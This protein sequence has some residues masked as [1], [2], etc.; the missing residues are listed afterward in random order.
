VFLDWLERNRRHRFVAWLQYMEPHDPYTPPASMRPPVPP[1]MP[2]DLAAGWV[3]DVSRRLGNP[4]TPPLTQ[5]QLAYLR[6]LYDGEIRSWDAELP[7]LLRGLERLGL[8][9]S[10]LIVVT[11]DHGEEFLEHGLLLH[12]AHLYDELIHVPLVLAG[13]SVSPGRR[14]DQVQGIDLFPTLAEVLGL[15][16]P[17]HLP[18]RSLL[19]PAPGR[20]AFCA[21]DG[22]ANDGTRRALDA[23]RRPDWKLT[24]AP[25]TDDFQLFDLAADPGER[26]PL[27]VDA[28]EGPA[29]R[30]TLDDFARTAPAPPAQTG[31][32]PAFAEKLRAL[33]YAE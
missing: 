13:P 24:P 26:A 23:V 1:G 3:L 19:T 8:R 14:T 20:P 9:D 28:G 29:L 31:R 33:G 32:D 18:G 7:A 2:S 11:S 21:T 15:D 6:A 10:T 4:G 27:P 5:E 16:A 30:L 25:L 12:R 17:S 22:Q